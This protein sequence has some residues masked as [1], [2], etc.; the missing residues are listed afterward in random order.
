MSG[1]ESI[2]S[3]GEVLVQV[4]Y[5]DERGKGVIRARNEW[6]ISLS[7]FEPPTK[8]YVDYDVL[9]YWISGTS[10]VYCVSTIG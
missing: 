2:E 8:A 10:A 4:V 1:G 7:G 9:Y 5:E 3:T 6:Q